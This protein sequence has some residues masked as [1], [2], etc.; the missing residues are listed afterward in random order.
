[1]RIISLV[2]SIMLALVFVVSTVTILFSTGRMVNAVFDAYVFKVDNCYGPRYFP[3]EEG[4][5]SPKEPECVIDYNQAKRDIS[6]GLALLIVA[7]P[8]A[9]FSYKKSLA[10]VREGKA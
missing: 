7:A 2:V 5:E 3:V 6:G 1:M 10:L 8:L 9:Y 4:E